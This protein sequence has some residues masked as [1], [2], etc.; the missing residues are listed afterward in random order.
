MWPNALF[1]PLVTVIKDGLIIANVDVFY[2]HPAIQKKHEEGLES[3]EFNRKRETQYKNIL[4][5]QS[6][7]LM[8][9]N[10]NPRGFIRRVA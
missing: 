8:E 7:L 10:N 9:L 6:G 3:E 1:L 5:S 2:V 4:S